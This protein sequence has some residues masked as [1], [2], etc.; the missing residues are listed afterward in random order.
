MHHC[1]RVR[2]LESRTILAT[3]R[4]ARDV[5]V[6][7]GIV[8]EDLEELRQGR[9][10]IDGDRVLVGRVAEVALRER[11]ALSCRRRECRQSRWLCFA[12]LGLHR[13]ASSSSE[14]YSSDWVVDVQHVVVSVP[15]V[16]IGQQ[17]RAIGRHREGSVLLEERQH[18]ARARTSLQP[19][20]PTRVRINAATG[21]HAIY[22]SIS[23]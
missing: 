13:I 20:P 8:R 3:V 12:V 4:L 2:L 19:I 15:G 6:V 14:S 16:G 23:I 5:K 17:R 9:V 22:L 21:A 1:S 10:E 11:E 7:L 18:R